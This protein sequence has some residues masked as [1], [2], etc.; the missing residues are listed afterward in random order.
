MSARG[1][2]ALTHMWHIAMD[3]SAAAA[4]RLMRRTWG[5]RMR[6]GEGRLDGSE[7]SP[8]AGGGAPAQAAADLSNTLAAWHLPAGLDC[9]QGCSGRASCTAITPLYTQVLPGCPIRG[10]CCS[11]GS[12]GCFSRCPTFQAQTD[13]GRLLPITLR[14]TCLRPG[15][16]AGAE[17]PSTAHPLLSVRAAIVYKETHQLRS[18]TLMLIY[19]YFA[20]TTPG[21]IV[22]LFKAG[23]RV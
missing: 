12:W 8:R 11:C 10:G 17:G 19:L 18:Y 5:R 23:Q 1:M 7:H 16:L 9:A 2:I 14:V 3:C 4:H 21:A 20:K 6:E 15:F 22:L 13:R